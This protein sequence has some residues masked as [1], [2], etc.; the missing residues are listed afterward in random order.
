MNKDYVIGILLAVLLASGFYFVRKDSKL[1][2]ENKELGS[3]LSEL[4]EKYDE[5]QSQ[6]QQPTENSRMESEPSQTSA[7]PIGVKSKNNEDYKAVHLDNGQ[8]Y[9][10]I[11]TEE[12]NGFI[13][14]VDIFYFQVYD[15]TRGI[16][17]QQQISLV[18][19]GSELH[20]PEDRM[21]I[22]NTNITFVETLKP[23]GQVA[24][25]I[26]MY[27]SNQPN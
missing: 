17:Q 9:F 13:T 7:G 10:G 25:A 14:L 5:A 2:A 21:L 24:T 26:K 11:V 27:K 23:D 22:E 16:D 12:K 18:K 20:G 15:P 6:Q 4:Q 1:G 3:K 8:V 19:L